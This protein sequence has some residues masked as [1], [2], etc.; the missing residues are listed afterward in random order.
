MFTSDI[1]MRSG[2]PTLRYAHNEIFESRTVRVALGMPYE[3]LLGVLCYGYTNHEQAADY[4]DELA[5][6]HPDVTIPYLLGFFRRLS[7]ELQIYDGAMQAKSDFRFQPMDFERPSPT[8]ACCG[9]LWRVSA[10]ATPR[11]TP[12]P[13]FQM[14]TSILPMFAQESATPNE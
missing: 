2:G 13:S 12:F 9:F 5:R 7:A 11:S 14:Q 3:I 10:A 8:R 6:R 4:F 1:Q